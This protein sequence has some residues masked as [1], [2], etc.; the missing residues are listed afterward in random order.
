ILMIGG[1]QYQWLGNVGNS[2]LCQ[3]RDHRQRW[4]VGFKM[5]T[6]FASPAF[7]NFGRNYAGARDG[8]VYTYSQDGP[9]AYQS[10][11]GLLLAPVAKHRISDAT[12]WEFYERLD[13]AGHPV[14][15]S[16]IAR[17]TAVFQYPANCE[18]V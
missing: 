3:S 7:L 5:D 14:W 2:L 4:E 15:T 10:D 18:R 11:N 12:A 6:S 13:A 1:V 16:D 17:R 9:S 8:F